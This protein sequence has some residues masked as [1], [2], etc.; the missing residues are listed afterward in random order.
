MTTLELPRIGE[1]VECKAEPGDRTL[2]SVT[3]I[4]SVL[5]KPALI[6]WAVNETAERTVANLATVQQ[7]LDEGV[8]EAVAYVA[9]LRWKTD[10]RLRDTELGTLAHQFFDQWAITGQRPEVVPELHPQHAQTGA[11]LH[12]DDL[13][14]LRSMLDQFDRHWLQAFCP[15]YEATEVVVYHPDYEYAGQADGFVTVDGKRL[16]LDYKTSRKTWTRAGKKRGPYPEVGLQLAAYRHATHAAVWRARRYTNRSRRYYLLNDAEREMALP[17]PEVD[18]GL[19]LY[20]TPHSCDAYPVR[21]DREMHEAFLFCQEMARWQFNVANHV[22]GNP[23]VPLHVPPDNED[24]PFA[25]L[26]VE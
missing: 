19:A 12:A 14:A 10:G 26:P 20:V 15:S 24:D 5:D 13:F 18:D 1:V 21:C 8:D 9:G 17:V 4:I 25:G 23:L 16:I 11:V 6:P 3:T 2:Y 7:R 22:V